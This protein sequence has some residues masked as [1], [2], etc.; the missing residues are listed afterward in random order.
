[1]SAALIK[2][3]AAAGIELTLSDDRLVMKAK[4]KPLDDLR[5]EIRTDKAEIVARLQSGEIHLA[6]WPLP[7]PK[8]TMEALFGLNRPL[9]QLRETWLAIVAERPL[10]VGP[11]AWEAARYDAAL[12]FG[13]LGKKDRSPISGPLMISL[14]GMVA[15]CGRSEVRR[16]S[17]SAKS[18]RRCL[19]VA[20]GQEEAYRSSK[21]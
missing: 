12:L 1:M 11:M 5:A 7:H 19:T 6:W 2:A 9:A 4:H 14:R 3:A 13:G 18:W 16:W 17:Q 10:E 8:I 21:A 15:S 20:F